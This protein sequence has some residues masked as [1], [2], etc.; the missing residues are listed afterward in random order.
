MTLKK[1]DRRILRTRRMIMDAF[2]QL[3]EEKGFEAITVSDL[4][5]KA[6]INRG[7]FYQHYKDKYDLLEQSENEIFDGLEKI[8]INF[9]NNA[10]YDSQKVI[11]IDD[12]LPLT[13]KLYEFMGE[14]FIFM[15]V[16]LGPNGNPS[17]QNRL[18]EVIKKN[19]LHRFSHLLKE[20][21]M[22]VPSDYLL[23][24]VSSAHLGLI[25]HWLECGMDRP[26]EEVARI[27]SQT[28]ILGPVKVSGI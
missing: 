14:N 21:N 28:V 3:L 13:I 5:E 11:K 17:F 8:V 19:L 1:T 26:P 9:W 27:L 18:K 25:Q 16:I 2:T 6:D 10:N 7:T 23:A 22:M 24:Y 4:T 12:L 20:E 15:K